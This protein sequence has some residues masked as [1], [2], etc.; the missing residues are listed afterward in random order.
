MKRVVR[1]AVAAAVTVV[2]FALATWVSGALILPVFMKDAGIRWGVAGSLGVAVAALAAMWGQSFAT[3]GQPAE[4]TSNGPPGAAPTTT[5]TGA[6]STRNK[7]SRGTFHAPVIQGRDISGPIP[8]GVAQPQNP[9]S[10][11]GARDL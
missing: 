5:A 10:D 4:T 9:D 11:T 3:S 6:G 7:I 8:G 1:W 2:A